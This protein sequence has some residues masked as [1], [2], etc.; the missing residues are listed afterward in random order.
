MTNWTKLINSNKDAVL[1]F[2]TGKLSS[3]SFQKQFS[4]RENPARVAVRNYGT[5][6]ARRLARKALRHRGISV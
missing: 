3:T 4:G 2:A 6:Y 1:D 5:L